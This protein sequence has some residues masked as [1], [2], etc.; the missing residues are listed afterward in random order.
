MT[1][2]TAGEAKADIELPPLSSINT[3][4]ERLAKGE[5]T[6]RVEPGFAG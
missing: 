4:F 5:V 6:P 2:A 1:F 3:V